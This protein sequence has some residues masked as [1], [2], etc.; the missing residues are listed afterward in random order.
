MK[1]TDIEITNRKKEIFEMVIK[2]ASKRVILRYCADN[3]KLKTR[4]VEN[5]LKEINEEI[6]NSFKEEKKEI[7]SKYIIMMQDLY[8]KN[9]LEDDF[10]ECRHILNDM[11]DR[12]IG[13]PQQQLDITSDESPIIIELNIG[14]NKNKT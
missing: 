10:R 11:T 2:G 5:Y 14:E 6:R 8:R 1:G 12:V 7:L 13:K 9:Y 4:Q 3:W